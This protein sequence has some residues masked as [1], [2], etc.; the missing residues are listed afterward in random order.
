MW[1]WSRLTKRSVEEKSVERKG[2]ILCCR[3]ES[4]NLTGNFHGFDLGLFPKCHLTTVNFANKANLQSHPYGLRSAIWDLDVHF[5]HLQVFAFETALVSLPLWS[6]PRELQQRNMSDSHCSFNTVRCGITIFI[7][8]LWDLI[9]TTFI[10]IQY[11]IS[12]FTD[13]FTLGSYISLQLD[14]A[15]IREVESKENLPRANV[16][17]VIFFAEEERGEVV[18]PAD[19]ETPGCPLLRIW[20]ETGR[21]KKKRW[22]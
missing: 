14:G 4:Y 3:M 6:F 16:Q 20:T 17:R 18:D 13:A 10:L 22:C 12:Q 8:H 9:I 7:V 1:Q 21:Q 15:D 5:T 19:R 2:K 11:I